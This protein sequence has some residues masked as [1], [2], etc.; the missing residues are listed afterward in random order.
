MA[1]VEATGK[2]S[3]EHCECLCSEVE[4]KRQE[5]F[6]LKIIGGRHFTV[7]LESRYIILHKQIRFDVN[8]FP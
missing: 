2:R 5:V 7:K 6:T 4:D 3:T 1:G 8:S